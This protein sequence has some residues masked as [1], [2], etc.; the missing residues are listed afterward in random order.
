MLKACLLKDTQEIPLISYKHIEEIRQNKDSLYCPYC[1][2]KVIFVDGEY[3]IKHFRHLTTSECENEPETEIH[4][5]MKQFIQNMFG[6]TDEEIEYTGLINKGFKPDAFLTNKNIA[7]EVQH[8]N[9]TEAEFIRRTNNYTREGIYVLWIFDI[10]SFLNE[11]T[12]SRVIKKAHELYYGRVYAYDISIG[13]I[14]PIHLSKVPRFV[15][16]FGDMDSYYTWYKQKRN[17]VVGKP[18]NNSNLMKSYNSWKD[19]NYL[20]AKFDD[21]KFWE[22][23]I[24]PEVG[25]RYHFHTG[26]DNC[27]DCGHVKRE[28]YEVCYEC[29]F[30]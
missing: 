9:I 23:D 15:P 26:Y 17:K 19:N 4:L 3:K 18:I 12:V 28:E 2:S 11:Q 22:G 24:L 29:R 30:G 7:I 6:L 14:I 1:R 5:H 27:P 20:I 25:E 16:G 21:K 13:N 10:N 8:S